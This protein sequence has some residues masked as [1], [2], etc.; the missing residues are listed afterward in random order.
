MILNEVEA[1]LAAGARG[2][3]QY[4]REWGACRDSSRAAPPEAT[5]V[6]SYMASLTFRYRG[7]LVGFAAPSPNTGSFFPMSSTLVADFREDPGGLCDVGKAPSRFPIEQ[8]V[9]G[10]AD[11][12][13]WS[14]RAGCRERAEAASLD[15]TMGWCV[16][17][18]TLSRAG[19]LENAALKAGELGAN[20]FQ[21]FSS[22][23]RMW[24]AVPPLRADIQAFRKAREKFD[25]YPLAI[26]VNYLVNLATLDP[27][28]RERSIVAFRG[29]NGA[30]KR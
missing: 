10:E 3:A 21:I 20:T 11:P 8:A 5:E 12:G 23:P 17:A 6:I 7:A 15:A 2:R 1:Y 27:V 18:S 22:S 30:C 28:V 14:R 25:L 13:N 29:E 24:R 19:S 26:H 16:S 4:P 9:A